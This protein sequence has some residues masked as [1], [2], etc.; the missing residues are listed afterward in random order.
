[1]LGGGGLLEVGKEAR[2]KGVHVMEILN[3]PCLGEQ[4]TD[5]G[6]GVPFTWEDSKA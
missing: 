5:W 4:G 1:M 3:R 2:S 6:Q